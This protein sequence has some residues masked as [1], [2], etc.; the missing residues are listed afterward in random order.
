MYNS[1]PKYDEERAE[2]LLARK[3]RLAV[4]TNVWRQGLITTEEARD[5]LRGRIVPTDPL[6]KYDDSALLGGKHING[7]GK[8]AKE[9]ER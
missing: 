6:T 8:E 2:M 9:S 3:L 5:V 4:V 1:T 7:F